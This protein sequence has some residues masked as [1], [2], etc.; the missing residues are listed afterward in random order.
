MNNSTIV[1]DTHHVEERIAWLHDLRPESSVEAVAQALAEGTAEDTLWAAGALT[2]TRYLNNQAR[3]LLGFVSH[4]MIGCED[5]RRLAQGQARRTR[6]LLIIQALH[7]VVCDLHDPCFAPSLLPHFWP[8]RESTLDA[9]LEQLRSDVRFG[10]YMRVDHRLSG[11]AEDMPRAAL[12][13]LLLDIGLE[14]MTSDDHTLITPVLSL[15]MVD[16]VGWERGFDMLRWG[17]RYSAS[18]PRS[19]SPYDRAEALR[20][21]YGLEHGAPAHEYQPELVA[22]LRAD[23]HAAAPDERPEIAACALARE[24]CAPATVLAA[25]SLVAA[26][27]LSDDR[28][29]AAR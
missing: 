2:A 6:W 14:G 5:A 29:C 8:L 20:E 25:V 21:R 17:L 22:G 19:F 26:D 27:F 7:Q 23:F 15:G 4:A 13:D 12:I 16:L 3:N 11:L 10:E 24:R 28:A 9:S 18:F 1:L